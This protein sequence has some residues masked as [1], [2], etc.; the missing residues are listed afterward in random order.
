LKIF[1][2]MLEFPFKFSHQKKQGNSMHGKILSNMS[3]KITNFFKNK[4]N[5][6][7]KVTHFVKRRSKITAPVFV[8]T[9]VTGCL[10]DPKISLERLS[11]M[12]KER[13]V[14]VTRQGLDQRFTPEA[15][16]LMKKVFIESIQE[17][18]MERKEVLNL[19]KP[20]R[21][22]NIQDS[23]VVTLPGSLKERWKGSASGSELKIQLLL[24]L[25]NHQILEVEVTPG[26]ESDQGFHAH[27]DEI[28]EGELYLQDLGY[29]KL[30]NFEKINRRGAYFISRYLYP[31]SLF[32][33]EGQP[34]DLLETL[35]AGPEH[36]SLQVKLG[37]KM[38]LPVRLICFRLSHE[39]AQKRIRKIVKKGQRRGKA[40]QEKTLEIAHWSIYI[41]NVGED[42]LEDDQ[43][44]LIY[45]LRWQIELFFKV[46]KTE[47]KIDRISSQKEHRILCELYAKLI[48]IV[49]LMYMCFPIWWSGDQECSLQK[50]FH[51]WRLKASDFFR[52]LKSI[53]RLRLFLEGFLK[54]LTMFSLKDRY[55]K[56]RRLS[57]QRIMDSVAQEHLAAEGGLA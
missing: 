21:C 27:L 48:C 18:K 15:S 46:C 56:K 49:A 13:G 39:D 17:F 31:T 1:E 41:T 38:S 43:V 36:M 30:N 14:K 57:Y 22:V 6:V 9:L 55:R 24:D 7:D 11:Y 29:F 40:P 34:I 23:S 16:L 2:K 44:H 35:K 10:A 25:M 12:M 50:A 3:T 32:D 4:V 51:L 47:A 53:Y 26:N 28:K 19:L 54:D 5:Q 52:A 42:L 33:N 37:K 20:F 45:S 8:E